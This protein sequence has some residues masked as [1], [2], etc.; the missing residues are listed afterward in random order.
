[1]QQI[2][3]KTARPSARKHDV[4][5]VFA[6]AAVGFIV[7]SNTFSASFHFDDNAS[8]VDNFAIRNIHHLGAI[9]NFWPTRFVTYL[10]LVTM[11]LTFSFTWVAPF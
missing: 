1:M 2:H 9:W 5:V 4:W 10:S 11:F 6:L 7:Y 8:I 3:S